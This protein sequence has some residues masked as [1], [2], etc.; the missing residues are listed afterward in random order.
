MTD[1]AKPTN[2]PALSGQTGKTMQDEYS[3]PY[4]VAVKSGRQLICGCFGDIPGG[5]AEAKASADLI[6]ET[7]NVHAETGLTPRQLVEQRDGLLASLKVMSEK[8][9]GRMGDWEN[10]EFHDGYN[11]AIAIIAKVEA[12]S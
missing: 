8:F 6:A 3:Q 12:K 11:A 9:E 10:A 4:A 7:F 5:D 2:G 1:T